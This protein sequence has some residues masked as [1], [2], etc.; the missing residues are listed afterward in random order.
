MKY[1]SF[2]GDRGEKGDK[3]RCSFVREHTSSSSFHASLF[4]FILFPVITFFSSSFSSVPSHQFIL[5]LFHPPQ[6][7]KL[8]LT[9]FLHIHFIECSQSNPILS[10]IYLL[11]FCQSGF[12]YTEDR[13]TF[14]VSI[15]VYLHIYIYI[16]IYLHMYVQ[17]FIYSHAFLYFL[18]RVKVVSIFLQ[19]AK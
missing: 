8:H 12:Q 17:I 14:F 7:S 1:S 4:I 19:Q 6:F 2:Q 10:I 15:H 11:T 16:Y 9:I 5:L 18:H 13:H 3:V